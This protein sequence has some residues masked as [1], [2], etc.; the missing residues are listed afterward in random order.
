MPILLFQPVRVNNHTSTFYRAL[1][2][3]VLPGVA[4][5]PKK[6][7]FIVQMYCYRLFGS[8]SYHNNIFVRSK[9]YFK[10]SSSRGLSCP[11]QRFA[12]VGSIEYCFVFACLCGACSALCVD[13]RF[14][15]EFR[16]FCVWLLCGWSS[17]AVECF[18]YPPWVSRSDRGSVYTYKRHTEKRKRPK[19]VF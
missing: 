13:F 6:V 1:S 15:F 8:G 12:V 3:F 17:D 7:F 19:M 14:C 10:K 18:I 4:A 16:I 2:H 9:T 5:H 11:V